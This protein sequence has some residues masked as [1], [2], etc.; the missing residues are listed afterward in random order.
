LFLDI[1]K[2]CVDVKLSIQSQPR[3]LTDRYSLA[4]SFS[5]D[6]R[7]TTIDHNLSQYELINESIYICSSHLSSY[8]TIITKRKHF[9]SKYTVYIS[10]IV[11]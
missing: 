3:M 10:I 4:I 2:L 6:D 11:V 1:H 9:Y 8:K 7:Y 5:L